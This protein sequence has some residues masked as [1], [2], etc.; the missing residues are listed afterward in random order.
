MPSF[1]E[2]ATGASAV[3]NVLLL[4]RLWVRQQSGASE[5]RTIEGPV[6]VSSAEKAISPELC[7]LTHRNIDKRF[8]SF[9]GDIA[10]V[11]ADLGEVKGEID[12]I[13]E[14]QTHDYNTIMSTDSKARRELHIKVDTAIA[15]IS[16]IEGAMESIK[17]QSEEFPR[18]VKQ[19]SK[20]IGLL[21]G[22]IQAQSNK[23]S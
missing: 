20:D 21:H 18:D 19:L 1:S 17:R 5:R 6:T 2:Y 14:R 7:E 4:G 23:P 15:K 12:D 11:K 3:L 16:N 22:L 8:Q 9:E 13:K 10:E